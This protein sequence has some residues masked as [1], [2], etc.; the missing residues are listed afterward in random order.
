MPLLHLLRRQV[1]V[2]YAIFFSFS[3]RISDSNFPVLFMI[4][5]NL[6]IEIVEPDNKGQ[7][8]WR[9][10]RRCCSTK[11]V[12]SFINVLWDYK[13]FESIY[14]P[15]LILCNFAATPATS[16][17]TGRKVRFWPI[18]YEPFQLGFHYPEPIFSFLFVKKRAK[19]ARQAMPQG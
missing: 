1:R 13:H 4:F 18:A 14:V 15:C 7:W 3:F 19:R 2:R 9:W 6:L 5:S 12:F 17:A 16:P 8:R 10:R 11:W